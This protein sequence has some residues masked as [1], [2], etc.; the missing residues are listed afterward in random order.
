MDKYGVGNDHYCYP[1]SAVLKNRLNIREMSLLESAE[2]DITSFTIQQ[3]DFEPPPYNIDYLQKLH[4]QLF[5]ELY[6]WAGEIRDID[7]SKGRTRF[8]T[9]SRIEVEA[10]KLFLTLEGEDWLQGLD[11]AHFCIKLA[12]YYIE[13]NMIHPFR[14]GNGRVQRLFFEHL[15]LANGFILDWGKV[16]RDEWLNANIHGFYVNYQPMENIFNRIVNQVDN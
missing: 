14:E 12:E 13:F 1:D 15:V 7:I 9:Y 5:S 6:E 2:R 16:G 3:I 11:K 8:C 10:Q 4:Y